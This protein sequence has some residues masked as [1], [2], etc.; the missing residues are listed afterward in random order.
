MA[1]DKVKVAFEDVLPYKDFAIRLP[2]HMLYRLPHIVDMLLD[3]NSTGSFQF[4][5]SNTQV[6]FEQCISH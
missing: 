4:S 6:G 2:Q 5:V 1:Q 3:S